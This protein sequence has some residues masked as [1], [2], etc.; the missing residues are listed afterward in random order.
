MSDS[1]LRAAEKKSQALTAWERER[2][3]LKTLWI[4][5]VV[6]FWLSVAFQTVLYYLQDGLFNFVLL[7]IIVGTMVLGVILKIRVQLHLNKKVD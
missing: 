3:R 5:A 2:D 6:I 7:S 1:K 4:I